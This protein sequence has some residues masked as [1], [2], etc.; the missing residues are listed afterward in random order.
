[1]SIGS[2][3]IRLGREPAGQVVALATALALTVA[4]ADLLTAGR[5]TL[6]FDV[7]FVVIS[8][9]LAVVVT[10]RDFYTVGVLPPLLMVG[11]FV[12]VALFDTSAVGEAD[13][14]VAQAVVSG[15]AGHSLALCVGYGLSLLLLAQRRRVIAAQAARR[16]R[17]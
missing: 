5:V 6:L 3:P 14:S 16:Q 13:D 15:L 11:V 12:L 2:G 10:P 1:M 9:G 4:A 8:A 17:G 7:C